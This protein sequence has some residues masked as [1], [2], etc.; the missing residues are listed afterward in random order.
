[1]PN[2]SKI[3]EDDCFIVLE[4]AKDSALRDQPQ[5]V[6]FQIDKVQHPRSH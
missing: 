1:M 2:G 6:G 5:E 3:D 4:Q